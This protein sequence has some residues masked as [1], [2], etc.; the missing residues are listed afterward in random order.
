[1][2]EPS[3]RYVSLERIGNILQ[4]FP[5]QALQVCANEIESPKVV[6]GELGKD[7]RATPTSLATSEFEGIAD[8]R[9]KKSDANQTATGV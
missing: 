6:H 3:E 9:D 7:A 4:G 2:N 8:G 1:M 5:T